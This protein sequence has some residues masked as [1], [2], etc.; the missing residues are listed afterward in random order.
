MAE[1]PRPIHLVAK[2]PHADIERIGRAVG[3]PLLDQRGACTE[4]RV[5]EQVERLERAAGSE[6]ER[7]HELGAHALTPSCELM[8]PDLVRLERVPC[9]VQPRRP[10]LA[11]ADAV[12]P[13]VAGNK[14]AAWVAD[15][16]Y[17]ELAHQIHHVGPESV[18]V[19]GRMLGLVDPVVD[20]PTEVLDERAEQ[21]AVHRADGLSGI[22]NDR[23][24]RLGGHRTGPNR[25]VGSG[26]RDCLE[27]AALGAGTPDD[28]LWFESHLLVL[29]G[30]IA[31]DRLNF[32]EEQ[33]GRPIANCQPGLTNRG[34]W[35]GSRSRKCNVIVADNRHIVRHP[36]SGSHKTL[37][38]SNRQ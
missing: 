29:M 4:V 2:A 7:E 15:C 10:S 9:E 32:L 27:T 11:R 38:Q 22:D 26:P 13:P 3:G 33:L 1:L 17:A 20:A 21:A 36:Q 12:L 31:V 6:V 8:Q 14:V 30:N 25:V 28:E 34:Q 19:G 18:R 16:G 35:Y 23:C 5:L 37:Q 24:R